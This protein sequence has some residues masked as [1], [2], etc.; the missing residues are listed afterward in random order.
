MGFGETHSLSM[1]S[2]HAKRLWIPI[3]GL[4]LLKNGN[5][6]DEPVIEYCSVAGR[7]KSKSA[8]TSVLDAGWKKAT[9]LFLKPEK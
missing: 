3:Y 9:S 2:V 6:P 7:L 5:F 1:P 4:R 8:S